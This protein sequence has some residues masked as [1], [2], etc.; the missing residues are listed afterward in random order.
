M[1]DPR[2]I[3]LLGAF[4]GMFTAAALMFLLYGAALCVLLALAVTSQLLAWFFRASK[5]AYEAGRTGRPRAATLEGRHY[6]AGGS[7]KQQDQINA[8]LRLRAIVE[9]AKARSGKCNEAP[10]D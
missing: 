2:T 3:G 8:S 10:G 1:D 5:P 6:R 9:S 4:L 7:W